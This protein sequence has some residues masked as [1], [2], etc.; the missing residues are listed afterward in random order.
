MYIVSKRV[1]VAGAHKLNLGYV[2]KCENLHG[3]N[4]IITIWARSTDLNEDGMVVDFTHIKEVVMKFDH[5]NINDLIEV[6][7]TAENMAQVICE[8]LNNH[9]SSLENTPKCYKVLVIESEGNWASYEI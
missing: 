6:N 4:W 9:F 5:Q 1:E 3:H 8:D 7:P 2:S